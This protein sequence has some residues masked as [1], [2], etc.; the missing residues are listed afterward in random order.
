MF[1]KREGKD[2]WLGPGKVVFQDGKVVFVRHG[3]I[4][5]RVSPNRLCKINNDSFKEEGKKE[6]EKVRTINEEEEHERQNVKEL[7]E[8]PRISEILGDQNLN[9]IDENEGQQDHTEQ[10]KAL[11]SND[12]IQYK[13]PQS[14]DWIQATVIS[15]AGKVTGQYK[16]WFNV[17][18]DENDS[19]SVDLG[20]LAWERLDNS[21]TI[22]ETVNIT[23]TP[24]EKLKENEIY[25]AKQKELQKLH[26][27][28]TYQEV[29]DNGQDLISTKWVITEKNGET[30]AR[31]VACGFEEDFPLPRDSPTVGKG[32]MRIFLT[33]AASQKWCIKTTDIK[34]AFLQGK[35][36]ERD[37]YLRPPKESETQLGKIWK[38]QHCLYGLKDGA[39][40]F[41]MSVREELL[42]LGCIQCDLDPAMFYLK[43]NGQLNGIICC[44]VDDFLHA[45]DEHLDSVMS[46]LRK[47]FS[48]GKVEEKCFDYIG[49]H[50][51]QDSGNIMIDHSGYM[52]KL[53]NKIIDPKRAYMNVLNSKEQTAFRQMVGQL[54]WAVQGSRPDM[55]FEMINLS[56]KLKEGTVGDLLR[57]TKAINRLKEIDSVIA[58]P[59]LKADVKDWRIVTFTDASLG[60]LNNGAGSTGAYIIWLMDSN[61]NCC[62]LSWKAN[63]IK[64]VV[65]ST[66]A[67]EALSL[68]EGLECSYYYRKIGED[69]TGVPP[70]TIPI[71]AYIDNKSVIE[72]L[73]S[74]K[75]VDDKRLRVDIAA[76][77]E[78]LEKNDIKEIN[79][80]PG[81]KQLANC[82][83]KLGASR[84]ELLNV[85]QCGKMIKDF[86]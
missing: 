40:Q 27:F 41:F 29:E 13:M 44:H 26:F 12:R 23:G 70:R 83:T 60:N 58:F 28:N 54:N 18:D 52:Q 33:I 72:A 19:K 48:A 2:R 67:A 85:L 62:P 73:H 35:E 82:M 79:W 24:K 21:D 61:R 37:I 50:V 14:N 6:E 8:K 20:S 9:Q 68:Q 80:C 36:L 38:L 11:R 56:T 22:N 55:A 46:K 4:F 74:T 17:K 57:A 30:K 63:K 1:Y 65:R 71:V 5:V 81:N 76:I 66:I 78:S 25:E 31:L 3:G 75:L 45:G 16:N 51:I 84:Y 47:H 34:S 42:K 43:K 49:F 7:R 15:R 86:L 32:A 10:I 64:R 77:Q 59:S 53:D 69:I 39:R